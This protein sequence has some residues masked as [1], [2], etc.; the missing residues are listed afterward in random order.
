M[1]A[2]LLGAGVP[3]SAQSYDKLWKKVEQAQEKNLPKTVVELTNDIFQKAKEE[4]NAGQMLKAAVCRGSYQERLTPDSLYSRLKFMEEWEQTSADPVERA[5]LN[6]LL[7]MEY[8]DF[9]DNNSWALRQRTVVQDDLSADDVREWTSKQFIDRVDAL[10][11]ASL[12]DTAALLAASGLDYAPFVETENGSRFYYHDLYHLLSRRAINAY[13]RLQGLASDSLLEARKGGIYKARM[14]AYARRAGCEDAALLSTLDYLEWQLEQASAAAPYQERM[15]NISRAKEDYLKQLDSLIVRYGEREA[16]VEAYILKADA[17]RNSNGRGVSL[18]LETCEEG[19]KRYAS[20]KRVNQLCNLRLEILHPSL[21][22]STPGRVYPGDSLYLDVQYRN[23]TGFTL[24]LY[25]LDARTAEAAIRSDE[26]LDEAFAKERGRLV[27]TRRFSLSPKPMA[28][29]LLPDDIP[30]ALST[31]ELSL[32]MPADTGLYL[33]VVETGV[34]GADTELFP[35]VST[36][37]HPLA[38]ALSG[39]SLEVV[40]LDSRSGHPVPGAEVAFYSRGTYDKE[41]VAPDHTATADEYGRVKVRRKQ[42]YQYYIVRKGGDSCIRPQDVPG[43]YGRPATAEESEDMRLFTDRSIYRPGQT[44]YVKGVAFMKGK[45]SSRVLSGKAYSVRLLDVNRKEVGVQQVRTNDFGSFDAEFTLP[46]A[47]LNGNYTI[48]VKGQRSVSFKVEEY[49]R[50][51][52]SIA[53]DP[54]KQAYAL[55]DTV[56]LTGT[57]KAYN[58]ANLQDVPLAY[59]ITCSG[60]GQSYFRSEMRPVVAD[61]VRVDASGCFSIPVFLDKEAAGEAT[62][63]WAER[64][65]AFF[66]VNASVTGDNGE[67]QEASYRLNARTGEY[68]FSADLGTEL[69][70]EDTLS[71]TFYIQ[72]ND[73]QQ[74]DLEG[75]YRL[76]RVIDEREDSVSDAPTLEAKFRSGEKL[77]L[78]AWRSL[79]SGKYRVVMSATR[80]DGKEV[81]NKDV[82]ESTVL[83]FSE[84]D[85]R[86]PLFMEDYLVVRR[87]EFSE[88]QPA[89]FYYGTSFK[90]AYVLVDVYNEQGRIESTV[91]HL[92]DSIAP[93]EFPYKAKY[94]RGIAVLFTF[95]KE[96][97]MH[98]RRIQ[99]SRKQPDRTL[100]MKWSVFRDRLRPGQE[101]EWRLSVTTPQ[102]LP[103]PAEVLALMYDA[104]LDQL[105]RRIQSFGVAYSYYIP[106]YDWRQTWMRG[107]SSSFYFPMKWW[108]VPDWYYDHFYATFPLLENILFEEEITVRGYSASTR[109][110]KT[111]GVAPSAALQLEEAVVVSDAEADGAMAFKYVADEADEESGNALEG[112]GEPVSSDPQA[113]RTNFA[114]TAFFYPQLRTDEHG[115]VSFSFTMPQS[116]TTWNFQAFSHTKDMLTGSLQAS[117][118][119]AKEF[120][121]TP[122]LPRFVRTGDKVRIAATIANLTD[123][124]VK[125]H[126]VLTLFDPVTERTIATRKERFSVEAKRSGAVEFAF[127]VPEDRDLLGVRIVADGGAFSDGEQHL[128]PVLSDK[129]HVVETLPM[130]IRG[131]QTRVFTLDSLFNRNSPTATNRK[132]TIEYTGNPAWYAVQALPAL[133]SPDGDNVVSWAAAWYANS[134][135]GYIASANPR[136]K[137][138]FDA[139][140]AQGGTKET[141]LSNLQKNQ[142][143]K[144]IL[145]SESPWLLEAEDEAA[146]MQRIATLFDVNALNGRTFSAVAKLKELQNSDGSWSWYKGMSGSRYMTDFVLTLLVRQSLLTGGQPESDVAGMRDKAFDYLHVQALKEYKDLL[147]M[148][149]RY[150]RE[151]VKTLSGAALDYL[152]LLAIADEEVPEANRDAYKYFMERVPNELSMGSMSRMAKA[153]VVLLK[154]GNAQQAT[155]LTASLKEH[156]VQEDELGAHFAFFDTPYRWGMMPVPVHVAV[157]EALRMEGGNDALL[158]EMKLWLLK[159]KQ[160]T[161]WDSPVAAAD[162]VYALLCTGGDWLSSRGDVRIALGEE[163]IKTLAP[164]AD[165]V[166]G[167]SYVKR[168]FDEGSPALQATEIT[169]EKRDDGIA[170]GAAYAQFLSPMSDLKQHGGGLSVEKKLYVERVAADGS[171]SLQQLV[172]GVSLRVGDKVTTRITISLDRAMDF[173]QLKDRRAACLEP[174]GQLSGYRWSGGFGYYVEVEDAATNY[175]FD[176]LGKGVYVLE[177]IYRVDRGGTYEAGAAT[178]QCAYAPEYASHST[179]GKL[180]VE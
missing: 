179:G 174:T 24:R 116:L 145:L 118:V 91:L 148:E 23:L 134:L 84:A 137:A 36:R 127:D 4:K 164:G 140:R 173:V 97:E 133:S 167:L 114:E 107:Q 138:V 65:G 21:T 119:T 159:Q 14:E 110:M 25:R 7:A 40:V 168:T 165:A 102:G 170:W 125:G 136:I 95:V 155:P 101:E 129:M 42:D 113:L 77:V 79:P 100:R 144:D 152:Y 72:N 61:T 35:V 52:F 90:D 160:T 38:Q 88:E 131:G 105:Y 142:D 111:A 128:L 162:A 81:S 37:F 73:A 157:M 12:R 27:D 82:N 92:D 39:D 153:A 19:I 41:G 169:V 141:F 13:D 147:R 9:A 132:L 60:F 139:W 112:E 16:C 87:A 74:L 58:S 53:F 44:V 76:Y 106:Y 5:M 57:V 8:A 146:Q 63:D 29:D 30:Y 123:K 28:D 94:G 3:A 68:I 55:G 99:L 126:A 115:E 83:L 176:S 180:V 34:K 31:T 33:A 89:Y 130:P 49:K 156:L 48:E 86:P 171:K 121:L 124:K 6:S 175:F 17:L 122:N 75:T 85:K 20:T 109:S 51:T 46:S 120:M 151:S 158:E 104:S 26:D 98:S 18:A 69:C 45:E 43:A 59:T 11:Q 71:A 172:P 50:P 64:S 108:S 15:A 143:V 62:S 93:M 1:L 161:T 177:H 2:S 70:K 96:G 22:V 178:M 47:C 32:P 163:T 67:T 149:K 10:C 56:M 135:A 154:A 117:V 78:D 166:P 150:G 80:R 103:A 66:H 54:V